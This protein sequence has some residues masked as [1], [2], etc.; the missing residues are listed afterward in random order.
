MV[1]STVSLPGAKKGPHRQESTSGRKMPAW[2]GECLQGGLTGVDH[3]DKWEHS[4]TEPMGPRKFGGPLKAPQSSGRKT[5]RSC[6]DHTRCRR[7]PNPLLHTASPAHALNM[8]QA[9]WLLSVGHSQ[10]CSWRALP[11]GR[12]LIFGTRED[13][14]GPG[15]EGDQAEI[16]SIT[17]LVAESFEQPERRIKHTSENRRA[18]ARPG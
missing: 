2:P 12:A 17:F 14:Q 13:L 9:V 7:E 8:W 15:H 11:A 18:L 4:A 1:S 5:P 16:L 3:Q 6:Q 10:P